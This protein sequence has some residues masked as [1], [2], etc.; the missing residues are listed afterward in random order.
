MTRKPPCTIRPATD[1][2]DKTIAQIWHQG[3]HDAHAAVVPK[4]ILPYRTL[5]HFELWLEG[6]LSKTT[7]AEG[8]DGI[9]GFYMLDRN[10]FAKLYVRRDARGSGLA[11][12]LLVHGEQTLAARG[13]HTAKL[14]CTVGNDRAKRFY[15]RHE[16]RWVETFD[17]ALWYPEPGLGDLTVATHRFEK[18][19]G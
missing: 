12:T 2:D 3:W 10:E 8:E 18:T 1:R 6:G 17:D 4:P 14:H 5:G 15:E 19:I 11:Q 13:A 16:W 7:L 9:L